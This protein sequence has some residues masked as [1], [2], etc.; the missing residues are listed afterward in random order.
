[1]ILSSFRNFPL[2]CSH[3]TMVEIEV[4]DW[5][6]FTPD[7]RIGSVRVS[8]GALVDNTQSFLSLVPASNGQ[9]FITYATFGAE[10]PALYPLSPKPDDIKAS[11]ADICAQPTHD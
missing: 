7:D 10:A 6:R 11:D 5:D 1:M 8:L 4:W 9:I 3:D 2:G